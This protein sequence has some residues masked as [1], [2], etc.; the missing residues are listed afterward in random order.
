MYAG[1]YFSHIIGLAIWFG[2]LLVAM[3][4]LRKARLHS[5]QQQV[6]A[7]WLSWCLLF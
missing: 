3:L 4:L 1:M 7:A 2:A 6:A 5:N